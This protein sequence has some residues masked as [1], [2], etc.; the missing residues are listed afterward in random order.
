M[1]N[2]LNKFIPV[3]KAQ[4][5][6]F[7]DFGL[8]KEEQILC[9]SIVLGLQFDTIQDVLHHSPG[10]FLILTPIDQAATQFIN[11]SLRA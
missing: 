10:K 8:T 2:N 4:L 3:I 7:L 11:Q 1:W 5:G 6:K 9:L